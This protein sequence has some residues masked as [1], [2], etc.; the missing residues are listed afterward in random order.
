MSYEVIDRRQVICPCGNG[1]IKM[2]VEEND[3]FQHKTHIVVDCEN[4]KNKY[5]I[6]K[7]ISK[8]KPKHESELY[9]LVE[10]S[11]TS[12]NPIKLNF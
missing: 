6:Q 8:A 2:V 4:C 1:L 10:K 11:R 7:E 12:S 5:E 9:Y 3:F